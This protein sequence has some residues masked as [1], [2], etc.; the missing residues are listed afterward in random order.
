MRLRVPLLATSLCLLVGPAAAGAAGDPIMPLSEVRA[1]MEGTGYSVFRG[2][3]VDPFA[4]TILDVVAPSATGGLEPR[5]LF[6][7]K[8]AEIERTGIARGFSGSPIY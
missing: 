2:Q 6:R 7:V 8:G 4:V 3:Q 1:G 5:I